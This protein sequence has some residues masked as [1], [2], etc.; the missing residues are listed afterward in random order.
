MLKPSIDELLEIIGNKYSLVI[1]VSKRAR[2]IVDDEISQ[3]LFTT[4][5]PVSRAIKEVYEGKV[6]CTNCD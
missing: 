5:K 3:G 4:K 2:G 1:T 6:K